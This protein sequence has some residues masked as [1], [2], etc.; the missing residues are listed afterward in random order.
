[1]DISL[2]VFDGY[3]AT[4]RIKA[5]NHTKSTPVIALTAQAMA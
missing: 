3:E 1:M 4:R 2:P 5:A